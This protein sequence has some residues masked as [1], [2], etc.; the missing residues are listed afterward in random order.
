MIFRE[1]TF[2]SEDYRQECAL[3]NAVLRLPLGLDLE[4]EDLDLE[5]T[6]LHFGLFDD[7]NRLMGCV[8]AVPLSSNEAKIRQMAIAPACQGQGHGQKLMDRLEAHLV[9]RLCLHARLTAVGFYEKM[10]YQKTGDEFREVGI[11]HVRMEKIVT[12]ASRG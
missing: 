5:K 4:D 7:S 1:I 10:S 6:Q 8:V 3:R 2:G 12:P 9:I 11:P